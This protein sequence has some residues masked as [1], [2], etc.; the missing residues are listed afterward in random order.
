[1]AANILLVE[2]EPGIQELLK[3]NL[4]QAGH[5]VT[6]TGDAQVMPRFDDGRHA[7]LQAAVQHLVEGGGW[8]Y[9]LHSQNLSVFGEV[10]DTTAG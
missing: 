9:G 2:D 4:T 7:L 5:Q 10:I 8:R 3:F 6:T 1:M